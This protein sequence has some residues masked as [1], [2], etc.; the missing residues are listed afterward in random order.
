MNACDDNAISLRAQWQRLLS[1]IAIPS[2]SLC[3]CSPSDTVIIQ[4]EHMQRSIMTAS[5]CAKQNSA[6][7]CELPNDKL[8]NA[9]KC[10]VRLIRTKWMQ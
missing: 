5:Q 3:P 6:H 2:R 9:R 10:S 1:V 8:Y 4:Y 7:A